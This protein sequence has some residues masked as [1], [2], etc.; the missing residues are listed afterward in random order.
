MF[1]GESFQVQ[2]LESEREAQ[3]KKQ[4]AGEAVREVDLRDK[5][6]HQSMIVV[7]RY[8]YMYL[9][10]YLLFINLFIYLCIYVFIYLFNLF[11]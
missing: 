8:I 4:G 5:K 1:S 7:N 10:I 6:W 3:Q 9:F 2:G 11:N